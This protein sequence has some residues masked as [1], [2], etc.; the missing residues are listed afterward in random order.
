MI[1]AELSIRQ[2]KRICQLGRINYVE[3]ILATVGVI[4]MSLSV[5]VQWPYAVTIPDLAQ[6]SA[7]GLGW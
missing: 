1:V 5:Y 7:E 4:L 2:P 3:K 6:I